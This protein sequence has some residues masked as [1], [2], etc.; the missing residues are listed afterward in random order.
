[1]TPINL[2]SS[3]YE[4]KMEQKKA[5]YWIS[6]KLEFHKLIFG[7]FLDHCQPN[8]NEIKAFDSIKRFTW[9]S[10]ALTSKRLST[11]IQQFMQSSQSEMLRPETCQALQK[12][13]LLLEEA[14]DLS[15]QIDLLRSSSI[16][17]GLL[18][19]TGSD[20]FLANGNLEFTE[21][22]N[23]QFAF[24]AIEKLQ[25]LKEGEKALFL[26]GST[27][28]ET[29]ISVKFIT[30]DKYEICYYNTNNAELLVYEASEAE[31]VN[32]KFW[33]MVYT[34]KFSKCSKDM[35]PTKL[36]NN[37]LQIHFSPQLI[38]AHISPQKENTCFFRCYL[39]ALKDEII[40]HSLLDLE[41]AIAEWHVFKACFG[42]FLLSQNQIDS[43][44]MK[45]FIEK[46]QLANEEKSDCALSFQSCIKQ[47]KVNQT[48]EIY[49]TLLKK[50]GLPFNVQ[51]GN[52][53]TDLLQLHKDLLTGLEKYLVNP[54]E[55][56]P[57]FQNIDNPW[58][59]KSWESF[60]NRFIKRQDIFRN[61]LEEELNFASS[62]LNYHLET[63]SNEVLNKVRDLAIECHIYFL[64]GLRSYNS[65]IIIAPIA[66]EELQ[67]ILNRLIE[68]PS[69]LRNL[70]QRPH[71]RT[72]LLQAIQAGQIDQVHQIY[73]LLLPEDADILLSDCQ[74]KNFFPNLSPALETYVQQ[75]DSPLAKILFIKV[76]LNAL[77]RRD[78]STF[79]KLIQ[80]SKYLDFLVVMRLLEEEKEISEEEMLNILPM[81]E[82]FNAKSN[83]TEK[84]L[85]S[86]IVTSLLKYPA[87]HPVF[88][89]VKKLTFKPF[90]STLYTLEIGWLYQSGNFEQ[91]HALQPTDFEQVKRKYLSHFNYS[92]T[93]ENSAEMIENIT[94]FNE[95][96]VL[97]K[98][99]FRDL[100]MGAFQHKSEEMGMKILEQYASIKKSTEDS[101]S[102][103]SPECCNFILHILLK[104]PNK[105][106][107][108]NVLQS[109]LLYK[110]TRIN[111]DQ[112]FNEMN[113]VLQV[114]DE[115]G[116][117]DLIDALFRE[118]FYIGIHLIEKFQTS[119]LSQK[120]A[121]EALSYHV[122]NWI[123]EAP[124]YHSGL[125]TDY[126]NHRR[127]FLKTWPLALKDL[128]SS[129]PEVLYEKII[130]PVFENV[131]IS[132]DCHLQEIL[133]FLK[134]TQA[135][136]YVRKAFA[137]LFMERNEREKADAIFPLSEL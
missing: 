82:E 101:W 97:Q 76:C 57:F 86:L 38:Q 11:E 68:N 44:Q 35:I 133:T 40:R 51:T 69:M 74:S 64:S 67:I 83:F 116:Y 75:S 137:S 29:L 54:K 122:M 13:I 45:Y 18:V 77:H 61:R 5:Q 46:K 79:L 24:I 25:S 2:F 8:A 87:D 7:F 104:E 112:S 10:P 110:L 42:R 48:I 135:P 58:I 134:E 80:H 106:L 9:F 72:I 114:I 28:H 119:Y 17:L 12:F 3:E 115:L 14:Q 15:Y 33:E 136:D 123:H 43:Q 27:L 56:Q 85:F 60:H 132:Q 65:S 23:E 62:N 59:A 92:F 130:Q 52:P 63:F 94:K 84:I 98:Q 47:G 70:T 1:M 88:E 91:I 100:L 120:Y 93:P 55:L 107:A 108:R 131:M 41:T 103:V 34:L 53:L 73:E 49:Q 19:L 30:H 89:Q 4:Q 36:L 121:V 32:K 109:L 16:R 105:W 71:I 95:L 31:I 50:F 128:N 125:S 102:F 99:L 90:P 21:N 126:L 37:F 96:P 6:S 129:D 117:H 20:L 26:A 127:G 78:F 39:A 22:N 66:A 124:L 81:L 118:R 111:S 113:S